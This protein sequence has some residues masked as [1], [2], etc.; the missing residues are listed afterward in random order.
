M[1]VSVILCHGPKGLDVTVSVILWLCHA[2]YRCHSLCHI[3]SV[4]QGIDAIVSVILC[5]GPKGLDVIVS[6]ILC[7]S[8]RV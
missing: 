8:C 7:Q 5:H 4:L 2:G 1:I 3:V 6:V